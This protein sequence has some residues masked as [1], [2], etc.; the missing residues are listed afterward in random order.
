MRNGRAARNG[1]GFTLI[2][3]LVVIAIIA[4]LAALLLPSLR[5]AKE[6]A[7]QTS[8]M[9]N[10]RQWGL[11]ITMYT[12]ESNDFFPGGDST[13][14]W[15][16][17]TWVS[18]LNNGNYVPSDSKLY[19][20]PAHNEYQ[21]NLMY[22]SYGRN[23]FCGSSWL[24]ETW[25]HST[26]VRLSEVVTPSEKICLADNDNNATTTVL[27]GGF[28]IEPFPAYDGWPWRLGRRHNGGANI[29]WCE[30]HVSNVPAATQTII[31]QGWVGTPTSLEKY[32]KLWAP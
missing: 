12:N 7:K 9:A 21:P 11:V 10:L 14:G 2:E 22:I 29:L 8:C 3:L 26:W 18:T 23:Y 32:W 25:G 6:M 27:G 15:G 20:C 16:Y 17:P 4:I 24:S 28:D 31:A 19:D 13:K 1:N 30:G 5:N